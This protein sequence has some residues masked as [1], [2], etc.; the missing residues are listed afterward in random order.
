VYRQNEPLRLWH[1]SRQTVSASY[2]PWPFPKR[3]VELLVKIL[4]IFSPTQVPSGTDSSRAV[5]LLK[6]AV[7]VIALNADMIN[8]LKTKRNLLYTV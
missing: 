7:Q 6:Q 4:K 2:G 3:H 8:L 5:L 1:L